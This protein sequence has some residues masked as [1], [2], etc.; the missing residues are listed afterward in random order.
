VQASLDSTRLAIADA[1]AMQDILPGYSCRTFFNDDRLRY[2]LLA[3]L[4]QVALAAYLYSAFDEIA[5]TVPQDP[6]A[7]LPKSEPH[8]S[9]CSIVPHVGSLHAL[10]AAFASVQDSGDLTHAPV[11]SAQIQQEAMSITNALPH[12]QLDNLQMTILCVC[13]DIIGCMFRVSHIVMPHGD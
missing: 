13:T 8:P 2:S 11:N 10:S 5:P 1:N 9:V 12:I 7:T 3:Q 6:P 4:P